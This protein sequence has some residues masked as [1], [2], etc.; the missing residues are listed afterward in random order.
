MGLTR[1][2][3]TGRR[4]QAVYKREANVK[5]LQLVVGVLSASFYAPVDDMSAPD[6][7]RARVSHWVADIPFKGPDPRSV[8]GLL[9]QQRLDGLQHYIVLDQGEAFGDFLRA[10]GARSMHSMPV[11]LDRAVN[12]F[13]A[14]NHAAPAREAVQ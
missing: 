4:S 10:S 14:K 9:E 2:G 8:P 5:R 11:S 13:L 3:D 1:G 6:D 12:G 7:F